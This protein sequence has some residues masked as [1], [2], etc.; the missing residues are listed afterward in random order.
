MDVIT[1]LD[2]NHS[3]FH[4]A[5][6]DFACNVRGRLRIDRDIRLLEGSPNSSIVHILDGLLDGL[7]THLGSLLCQYTERSLASRRRLGGILDGYEVSA[8][9][10]R[11]GSLHHATGKCSHRL[12]ATHWAA[13]LRLHM[14]YLLNFDT[15]HHLFKTDKFIYT[16]DTTNSYHDVNF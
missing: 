15:G 6:E 8:P 14:I 16:E 4:T 12:M 9:R 7:A 3:C 1:L 2:D 5:F 10:S 11:S 13:N